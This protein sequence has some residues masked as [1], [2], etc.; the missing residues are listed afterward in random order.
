MIAEQ[1]PV[2][3]IKISRNPDQNQPQ[4]H[5]EALLLMICLGEE[6]GGTGE[7][8]EERKDRKRRRTV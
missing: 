3:E 5:G 6:G 4:V 8:G 2:A 7:T 1:V